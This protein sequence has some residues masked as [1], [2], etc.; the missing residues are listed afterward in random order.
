MRALGGDPTRPEGIQDVQARSFKWA[1]TIGFVAAGL[2]APVALAQEDPANVVYSAEFENGKIVKAGQHAAR[3]GVVRPRRAQAE[4]RQGG[5]P[6]ARGQDPARAAGPAGLGG[7]PHKPVEIVVNYR[8]PLTIPT[9]PMPVLDEDR[10]SP[11]NKE[12]LAPDPGHDRR[13]QG[14]PRRPLQAAVRRARAARRQGPEH[15]L[16]DPGRAREPAAGGRQA[17]V[18]RRRRRPTSSSPTASTKPPADANPDN[19]LVDARA[20]IFSDPYFNLGQTIG[21]DRPARHRRAHDA[22]RLQLP[23]HIAIAAGPDRRRRPVRPVRPRHR[24][25][26]RDHRQRAA[27][28]T[29]GAACRRS[30]STRGTSTATTARRLGAHRRRLRGGRQLGSTA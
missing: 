14:P 11:R 25:R 27:S 9:F 29:T 10:D 7:D 20:Q 4:G 22:H 26:G 8:D 21:L 13:H 16:A 23:D 1:A 2:A 19:D 3:Q 6:P 12:M 28:A 30:A 5:P 15:L 17:P 18:R 24:V